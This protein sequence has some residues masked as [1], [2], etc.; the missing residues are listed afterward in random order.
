M[1]VKVSRDKNQEQIIPMLD[2]ILNR[3]KNIEKIG[4]YFCKLISLGEDD[5]SH[6]KNT[7]MEFAAKYLAMQ[8]KTNGKLRAWRLDGSRPYPNEYE[9]YIDLAQKALDAI[10]KIHDALGY[11]LEIHWRIDTIEEAEHEIDL[12]LSGITHYKQYASLC[13]EDSRFY[14]LET[15]ITSDRIG[16]IS[17]PHFPELSPEI[18]Y[19]ELA[20]I[21]DTLAREEKATEIHQY[22]SPGLHTIVKEKT[23][24]N[25]FKKMMEKFLKN[26]MP[27]IEYVYLYPRNMYF[28]ATLGALLIEISIAGYT[29]KKCKNCGKIF[30]PYNRSDTVY[31][32]RYSPQDSSKTCREFGAM[33]TYQNNLQHNE[34]MSLYRKIYMSKQMLIKRHPDISDYVNSFENFKKQANKW[35][36]DIKSGISTENHYLEWLRNIKL[37]GNTNGKHNQT[38]K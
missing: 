22:Y 26:G 37:R 21:E 29:F 10:T 31:C 17:V 6:F 7:A 38:D 25:N 8:K 27:S 20:P 24:F 4:N 18:N 2:P 19:Y 5:I 30:I 36:S 1:L 12:M 9:Q 32:E 35:K 13:L 15:I 11:F 14:K 16:Y 28:N 34:T 3:T 33:R 23:V